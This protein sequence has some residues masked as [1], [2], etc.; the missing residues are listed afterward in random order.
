MKF[1]LVM[2]TL[3]RHDDVLAFIRTI[4]GQTYRNF[5]LIIVDQNDDDRLL[6][7]VR[8]LSPSFALKHVHV[9]G[10]RGL[11]L[12]R[13]IGFSKAEGDVIC[14][15][16][17]D[18]T[19][20]ENLFENVL[21]LFESRKVDIVCGRAAD[22]S[23]RDIN[24]RF[25]PT[26]QPVTV[27]NVFSTHIEWVLF[28]KRQA[29]ER[30]GGF[31][32][33]V[34]VG[35]PTPWQANEGQDLVLSALKNGFS[36]WYDPGIYGH[37]PELNVVNPDARM[38]KKARGYARGMGYVLGKHD[39]S[40][41]FFLKYLIRSAGGAAVSFVKLNFPRVLYYIQ[42]TMGRMEGYWAGRLTKQ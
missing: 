26:A 29:F 13:N 7:S 21:R 31:D 10:V 40:L 2:S 8:Q 34:G 23:G 24:G 28:F 12:G 20:P 39:Y 42:V 19:Y 5:E 30:V 1:S 15:P 17:D 33:A 9:P 16:D 14:F 41:G 22:E 37:H 3:G 35:A 4:E 11:S 38:R 6:Q 32:E 27:D 18:C 36:A 25:E